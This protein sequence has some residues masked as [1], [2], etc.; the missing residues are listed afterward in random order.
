MCKANP[1]LCDLGGEQPSRAVFASCLFAVRT[2]F[3][4]GVG[5]YAALSFLIA[6]AR[7]RYRVFIL[8]DFREQCRFILIFLPSGS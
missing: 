5:F 3:S 4:V 2:C 8:T 1:S 6:E 7:F